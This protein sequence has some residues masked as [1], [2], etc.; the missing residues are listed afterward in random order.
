MQFF[1]K[2]LTVVGSAVLLSSA[3]YGATVSGTVKGPDGAPFMGAFVEAYNLKMK[4]N[5]IVLSNAQGRY[6]ITKVPAGDYR[7]QIRAV[8]YAV[9]PQSGVNLTADQKASY[10]FN[11]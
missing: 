7:L 6:E 4:A 3:C 10:D 2:L 8:G 11:L 9:D 1:R 5:F